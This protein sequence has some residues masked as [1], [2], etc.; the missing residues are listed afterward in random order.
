MNL[1]SVINCYVVSIF[2]LLMACAPKKLPKQEPTEI[3]KEIIN[4]WE[5]Q[6][7]SMF[8]HF[9]LY[10]IPAGVWNDKQITGYSEQIKGHAKIPTTEYRKLAQKF[11]PTLWNSDSIVLLAKEAGMKSVVITTKHHDG[12]SLFDTHYSKFDIVDATPYKKDLIKDLSNACKRHGLKF[13]VYY[14]T[15]DWDYPNALPFT[16]VRNS[17]SIPPL[18]HKYNLNQVEELLTNYG[19]V[20]EIWFDMGA[21]TFK[22]SKEMAGLVKK[23][24]PNCLVS[25]RI[26]NDQGDFV[27]MGDN[28]TP[29]FKMGV[30]WQTPA[31]MFDETWSYRSWQKR[32]DLKGKI[33]EKINDLLY[34]VSSGGNYLLNIGPKADGSLVQYEKKVLEGIGHWLK[35]HGEAV[36]NT[37]KSVIKKPY[38]GYITSKPNKIYLHL[39]DSLESSKIMLEGVRLENYKTYLLADKNI[40]FKTKQQNGN[41]EIKLPKDLPKNHYAT[42][43]VIEHEGNL[44]YTPSDV[45]KM[46]NKDEVLLNTNNATKYH[47]YSGHDYYSTQ[48]TIIK[49]QWNVVTQTKEEFILDISSKKDITKDTLILKINNK[50]YTVATNAAPLKIFL[51]KE[52]VNRIEIS[53]KNKNNPHKGLP[54]EVAVMVKPLYSNPQ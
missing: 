2:F 18:H 7:F 17:D 29:N 42:V 9:G 15:I 50:D 1:K 33:K 48:P 28:Y 46:N 6:K 22:Q 45:I 3:T 20:S 14:S 41:I 31:S 32:T 40:Q 44:V 52:A 16:S 21:P 53:L 38:W 47:S 13:G 27:V 11:N 35:T 8:I 26:W 34:I 43:I 36:Y 23:I 4:N 39:T 5:N 30:P 49:M 25:G 19:E 54:K 51:K 10:S 24:Q 37:Q 12:F